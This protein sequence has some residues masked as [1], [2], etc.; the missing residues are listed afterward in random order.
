MAARNHH[1]GSG[2]RSMT[3]GLQPLE[4]RLPMAGDVSVAFRAGVLTITGDNQAN[5][6]WVG[7]MDGDVVVAPNPLGLGERTRLVHVRGGNVQS[8]NGQI[9]AITFQGVHTLNV[10]LRGGDDKLSISSWPDAPR[11]LA[12]R[13]LTANLGSGNNRLDVS[14]IAVQRNLTVRAAGGHDEISVTNVSVGR[15]LTVN[16]GAGDNMVTVEDS[17]VQGPIVLVTG[18][19]RDTIGVFETQSERSLS[20]RAGDGDNV[21]T[22]EEGARSFA[23]RVNVTTGSGNDE[24]V[25]GDISGEAVIAVRTGGGNDIVRNTGFFQARSLNVNLGRGDNRFDLARHGNIAP[26]ILGP[27]TVTSGAGHDEIDIRET[28]VRGN[29]TVRAGDGDN[30]IRLLAGTR[31]WGNTLIATGRGADRVGLS[32][33]HIN[34]FQPRGGRLTVRT[35]AGAD[36]VWLL[37]VTTGEIDLDLGA[38][39]DRVWIANS[40]LGRRRRFAGGAGRDTVNDVEGRLGRAFF[41][42]FEEYLDQA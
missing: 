28:D 21:V 9:E 3:L 14:D 12:F 31:A 16:A 4:P 10:D 17:F 37:D 40:D 38:G 24:V 1:R 30:Q 18:R 41:Q 11:T 39:D 15:S 32:N 26:I 20:V 5:D 36:E 33:F 34:P 22:L 35:G 29:L 6:I 25:L 7:R 23:G 42:G 13:N 27:L 2:P 19:G 8:D